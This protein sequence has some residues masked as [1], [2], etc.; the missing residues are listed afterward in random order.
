MS[1]DLALTEE[2]LHAL[3]DILSH[4]ETYAEI[5]GFKYS[6]AVINYGYPFRSAT[7]A[8]KSGSSTPF[9]TAPNTPRPRS[10]MPARSSTESNADSAK[11]TSPVLQ[12]LFTRFILPLPWLRELPRDFWAVRV[13][14]ILCRLADAGLSESYD[15][16]ALGLRKTLA[17]GAST[18]IEMVVRGV[19]GGVAK[20]DQKKGELDLNKAEDLERAWDD[21]VQQLVHGNLV[22][23]MFPHMVETDD[24]EAHSDTMKGAA[25]YAIVHLATFIHHVF[26][27]SPEG[28][29]LLQLLQ[30]VHGLIPYKM[31][32]QTLRIGNAASMINGVIRLLLAK[33]SLGGITNWVGLT[34]NAEDGMNLLQRI[35]SLVLSWDAAEFK[36]SAEKIE[37]DKGEG[38]PDS[39]ILETLR[40]FINEEERVK[41]DAVR[42]TSL[43][44]SQSIVTAILSTTEPELAAG[45]TE[46][47]HVSALQYYSALLSV[48]DRDAISSAL[49]RQSPDHFTTMIR[50]LVASYEPFIRMVHQ[51]VDLR[52]YLE[53]AQAFIEEFI[54]TSRGSEGKRASVEDYVGLLRRNKHIFYRWVHD[55]AK[56][57]PE[58]WEEL[59]KWC[60]NVVVKFRQTPAENQ[61]RSVMAARLEALV[62]GLPEASRRAVMAAL[63]KH[64]KYLGELGGLSHKSLQNI[65]T[66][67]SSDVGDEDGSQTGPGVYFFRWQNLL[68][69]APITPDMPVGP[70]RRGKDVKHRLAMGKTSIISDKNTMVGEEEDHV[71]AIEAPDVRVVVKEL[72]EGF[73]KVLQELGGPD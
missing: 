35:I 45:L 54:T 28:Q 37:K 6:E 49:C 55:V 31:L 13:Q 21:F 70:I 10:P 38:R 9:S 20:T 17:T 19:L 15:K 43:A 72:G 69:T 23:E 18:L 56:N 61:K 63:D 16:G 53:A 2:Q 32:K 52:E 1:S 22:A 34:T 26:V 71:T 51:G 68:D 12:T 8:S 4:N 58:V 47:K 42:Q 59:R 27:T 25:D 33:M 48:R 46:T 67:T 66:S 73:V 57:C 40:D 64:A 44:Q 36:K 65:L 7:V 41:R 39:E 29:Y 11:S 14:G 30:N 50:E 60:L 62:V 3:F 5:E 24:L